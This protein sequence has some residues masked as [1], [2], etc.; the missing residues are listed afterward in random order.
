LYCNLYRSVD[1][2]AS[3]SLLVLHLFISGFRGNDEKYQLGEVRT[4]ALITA[5]RWRMNKCRVR[6]SIKQLCCSI[7]GAFPWP[8]WRETQCVTICAVR[9]LLRI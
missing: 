7:V 5:V 3:I 8:F 1:R 2:R 9:S 4:I 6:W